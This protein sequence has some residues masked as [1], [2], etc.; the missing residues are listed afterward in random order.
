MI[1][2]HKLILTLTSDVAL[3]LMYVPAGEFLMGS[4]QAIDTNA[5]DHELPQHKLFLDAHFIGRAPVTV[6]Q[7]EAFVQATGYVTTAEQYGH[8]YNLVDNQ[9]KEIEGAHWRAPHGS[10]SDVLQKGMHPV[11]L[12]SWYDTLAFCN[13]VTNVTKCKVY[14]PSEAEWEQAA[15]GLDGFI[16]PWGNSKP[17]DKLCNFDLH[18]KG[19]S[20]VGQYSPQGDSPFG[21]V[22]MAGNVIEWTRSLWGKDMQMPEY[23]YPYSKHRLEREDDKASNDIRRVVRGGAWDDDSRSLRSAYRFSNPTVSRNNILGFRIATPSLLST[24][25]SI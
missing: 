7:F 20:P 10:E 19:T 17:T 15:R 4:D 2:L 11:T 12:V 23:D 18:V 8:G 14:L 25:D 3:E 1:L 5:S 16:Y 6:E 13:W 9:W 24:H 21:C 22:D